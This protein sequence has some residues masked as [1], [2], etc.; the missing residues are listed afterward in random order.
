MSY[1]DWKSDELRREAGKPMTD[2]PSPTPGPWRAAEN[3]FIYTM[4][5]DDP[6]VCIGKAYH[7]P[8]VD[9]DRSAMETNTYFIVDACN[10]FRTAAE[11]LGMSPLDLAERLQD[12]GIAQLILDMESIAHGVCDDADA[13]ESTVIH[14]IMQFA[15]QATQRVKP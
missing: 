4:V 11:R 12:G 15:L 9:S 1:D 6:N 13:D 5:G 8:S 14:E 3:G 2:T 10:A 7:A